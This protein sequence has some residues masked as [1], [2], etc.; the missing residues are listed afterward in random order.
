MRTTL[1]LDQDL[2]QELQERA[3]RLRVPFKQVVNDAI[4]RG[5]SGSAD[6]SE[7]EPFR[8]EAQEC[9]LRSGFDDR[10]FN[11]LADELEVDAAAQELAGNR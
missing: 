4:R 11:Q 2:A 5:V 10:R 9:R 6:T 3:R 8:V 1:T 7:L